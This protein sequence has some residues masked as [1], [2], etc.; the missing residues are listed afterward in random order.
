MILSRG[1]TME[2]ADL[3]LAYTGHDPKLDELLDYRGMTE[4][5][6]GE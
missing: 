6:P 5:T 3:Y 1:N 2:Y 4:T